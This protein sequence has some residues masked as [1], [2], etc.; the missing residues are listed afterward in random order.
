MAIINPDHEALEAI[1][2]AHEKIKQLKPGAVVEL[3]FTAPLPVRIR[4]RLVGYEKGRYLIIK[5]PDSRD[6]YD[7]LFD[8]NSVVMRFVIE[9]DSGECIACRASIRS[10]L[11]FPGRLLFI[12]YP[13]YVE[14]RSLR[15]VTRVST[16]I[17]AQMA[18]Q[19]V[20]DKKLNGVISDIS[21]TGC[22]IKFQADDLVKGVNKIPIVITINPGSDNE[23]RILGTVM[24]HRREDNHIGVG[25]AF[26][27][28]EQEVLD[29]LDQLYIDT[30]VFQTAC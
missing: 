30:R 21:P 27:S 19:E 16:H 20:T 15:A 26:T 28:S 11:S 14:N 25:V 4:S 8:G 10:V 3:Q 9:G 6:Y 24:N 13:T 1:N 23:K 18:P 22:K 12:D 2:R 17:L 7:V 29:I 5:Q